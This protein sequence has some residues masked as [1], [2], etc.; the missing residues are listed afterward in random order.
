MPRLRAPAIALAL[1]ALAPLL[2]G[3]NQPDAAAASV[4]QQAVEPDVSIVTVKPAPRAVVRELPGRI[5]P[6]RISEVRP[7]VSGIIVERMFRQGGEVKAGDPLYQIDPRPFEV[8]V[9][10]SKA[11]L[12]RAEATSER[13]SQQARRIG[14]L[15]RERAAPEVENEKAIAA[16]RESAAEVQGRKA[17]LARATLNLDYA[18]IRA[19]IDGVVGAAQVSEGALVVQHDTASLAT[20]QQL[21]PVYADFTQSVG[22]LTH[23]RRAFESGDLER[24]ANDAIKVRLVLDDGTLYPLPGRLL[25]SEAKVDANTG[26]VTLRGEFANPKRELLPGLYVRVRIEQG[27]DSDAIAVPQQAIQRNAGGGSEVFIVK[28]DDRVARQ[29]VRTGSVQ[30]GQWLVTDGLKAGDRVV[31]EGFQKFA[32]GD[33]VKPQKWDEADVLADQASSASATVQR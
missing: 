11:A 8:E 12:A 29:A 31:V 30:D 6:T 25:F 17:D 20:I 23:L 14:L 26:Q 10:A 32:A 21:D 7:R 22:E 5:A 15:T 18:T 16:E 24:I 1:A 33:K 19:P 28:G 9:Q 27:I 4:S 3:C 13:A 2:A